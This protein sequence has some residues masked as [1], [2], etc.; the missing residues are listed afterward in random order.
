M[1]PKPSINERSKLLASETANRP[2]YE[3]FDKIVEEKK[4][5]ILENQELKRQR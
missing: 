1:R 3:R 4:K 2:I 5:K